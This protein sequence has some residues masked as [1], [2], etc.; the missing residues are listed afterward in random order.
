MFQVRAYEARTVTWWYQRRGDIDFNPPFQRSGKLWSQKDKSYL[1]DSIINE[2][3]FPKIYLADFNYSQSKINLT[4]KKFAVI[5][6]RQRLEAV[7]DF[8]ENRFSLADNFVL[9]GQPE[10]DLTGLR[11][12]ELRS[13]HP[14]IALVFEQFNIPVMSVITDDEAKINQLFV[15]MNR[16][17][18]L[19]GAEIRNAMQGAVPPAIRT[20]AQHSFF[21]DCCAFST[22]RGQDKN[23]AA[24]LL[25]LAQSNQFVNTK[26][27]DLD[28]FVISF[29]ESSSQ[30]SEVEVAKARTLKTLDALAAEFDSNDPRLKASGLIPV[31]FKVAEEHGANKL[32]DFLAFW[33]TLASAPSEVLDS[34]DFLDEQMIS[35]V[36]LFTLLKRNVNDSYAL[37]KLFVL[38]SVEF[39]RFRR[40]LS[41]ATQDQMNRFRNRVRAAKKAARKERQ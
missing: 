23:V 11:Y 5:D 30:A 41:Q 2:Y 35:R 19:T 40:G 24:K 3:D 39:Q 7:F 37:Q 18:P 15:R 34:A 20:V 25:L 29:Q 1:I 26:K 28:S 6:G 36:R 17:K 12:S 31:Y 22:T 33:N 38:L 4:N 9:E 14:Q 13:S 27:V 16:N 10:L 8:I 32:G 21:T